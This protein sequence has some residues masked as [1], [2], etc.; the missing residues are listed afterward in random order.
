MWRLQLEPPK[1]SQTKL[2]EF[3][4]PTG[5]PEIGFQI[6]G[7]SRTRHP[8]VCGLSIHTPGAPPAHLFGG[9]GGESHSAQPASTPVPGG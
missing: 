2:R 4:R 1:L 6:S 5:R 8:P 9:T 7:G 3:G